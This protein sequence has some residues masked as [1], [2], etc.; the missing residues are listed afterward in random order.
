MTSRAD[1]R[2]HASASLGLHSLDQQALA[3]L[4]RQQ[5]GQERPKEI[6]RMGGVR[7]PPLGVVSALRFLTPFEVIRRDD[8]Q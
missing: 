3:P 8:F 4:W 2:H 7:Q 6:S 5:E 1:N